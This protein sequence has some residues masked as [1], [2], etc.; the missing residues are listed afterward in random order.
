MDGR[1]RRIFVGGVVLLCIL[2]V[3]FLLVHTFAMHETGYR[4]QESQIG[5]L[6]RQVVSHVEDKGR[7]AISLAALAG[8]M[9]PDRLDLFEELVRTFPGGEH[10]TGLSVR[11]LNGGVTLR[12]LFHPL[13]EQ[14]IASDTA[15]DNSARKQPGGLE[16]VSGTAGTPYVIARTAGE[17]GISL[18]FSPDVLGLQ[19]GLEG[20]QEQGIRAILTLENRQILASTFSQRLEGL[21][22]SVLLPLR[23][24]AAGIDDQVVLNAK[25]RRELVIVTNGARQEGVRMETVWDT[26]RSIGE[27]VRLYLLVPHE[28]ALLHARPAVRY[29]M[30]LHAAVVILSLGAIAVFVSLYKA[31]RRLKDDAA[32]VPELRQNMTRLKE[33]SLR[34]S[35]LFNSMIDGILLLDMHGRILDCNR[36][37][38][39]MLGYETG[40]LVGTNQRLLTPP[41]FWQTENEDVFAQISSWGFTKDY[42]K[43]FIRK[44]GSTVPVMINSCLIRESD[45]KSGSILS[46]LRDISEQKRALDEINRLN[47]LLEDI[48]E[49]ST[50]CILTLDE[51]MR[52]RMVNTSAER[53]FRIERSLVDNQ[54]LFGAIP[55]FERLRSLFERTISE[56]KPMF[57][58]NE[59]IVF[60]ENDEKH[61]NITIYPLHSRDSGSVAI[62][63][64]DITDHVHLE[65]RLFQSQKME[66]LG[67]LASGFA[68][69][70]NNLLS[71][72]FSYLT[73]IRM[74]TTDEEVLEPLELVYNIARRA[75]TLVKHIVTFSRS[76]QIRA[77]HVNICTM[78][79]EVVAMIRES[80]PKNIALENSVCDKDCWIL[81]DQSQ[82]AQVLLNLCINARDAMPTGGK[83]AISLERLRISE[84][85][86]RRFR[87]LQPGNAVRITVS[88]TGMGIDPAIADK[89]F[90]PFFTTKSDR[91]G[92]GMGLFIVY[93]I[94]R[95][96]H[97]DIE[98]SSTPGR[99]TSISIFLPLVEPPGNSL[100]DLAPAAHVTRSTR[101]EHRG[102]LVVIDDEEIIGGALREGFGRMGFDVRTALTGEQGLQLCRERMPDLVI[103]DMIMPGLGGEETFDLLRK[104]FPELRIV[105][106][107]GFTQGDVEQRML[108]KGALDV[109]HKP[110]EM[111][112]VAERVA[113][114]IQDSQT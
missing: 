21:P 109:L 31:L 95:S 107:T 24:S 106:H 74:K 12:R 65:R 40:E 49:S 92:T 79:D 80:F 71:G 1:S 96:H 44:D 89:I 56:N 104:E 58:G 15:K 3:L 100:P 46:T 101:R 16:F 43:E 34:Y 84:E 103:L 42:E 91:N 33:T 27:P 48:I 61:V 22:V 93:G 55:F 57:Q 39:E 88:D 110:Y 85:D 60:G 83:L 37:F 67:T 94:L 47:S 9:V 45:T 36:T 23:D 59:T 52:I 76:S 20:L 75:S 51:R 25:G 97:G 18:Y 53:F 114:W 29:T 2:P 6:L 68:H 35:T 66:A 111:V 72:I 78:V 73:V 70:F 90:D 86:A 77:V 64:E 19:G 105:I 112:E 63:L 54:P 30:L 13:G 17:S 8:R 113:A 41:R 10:C 11:D 87:M 62:H 4:I 98:L 7:L 99:G 102:S 28:R 50:L 82:M 38:A 26:I 69:D 14:Q 5:D 32:Q 81:G 108:D